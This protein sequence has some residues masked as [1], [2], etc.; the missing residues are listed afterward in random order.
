[1]PK[2]AA[3]QQ[4][5]RKK[6]YKSGDTPTHVRALNGKWYVR[7]VT[8]I[9]KNG[10]KKRKEYWR[11]CEPQT[12]ERS[13]EIYRALAG[14]IEELRN[15]PPKLLFQDV[16]AKFIAVEL[17]PASY[18]P[19]G[20]KIAG[21]RSLATPLMYAKRLRDHFGHRDIR[22]LTFG[23]LQ[24]YKAQLLT[25]P[26]LF[27]TV[28]RPRSIRSV[29]YE[30]GVLR[31]ILNFAVRRRWLD[32]SPF[33]DGKGIINPAAETKR[34]KGWSRIEEAQALALCV[35][36]LVHLKPAIICMVDGGFRPGEL[37]KCKW[38]DVN[39]EAG[40]MLAKSYKGSA[41]QV[42]TIK[43]SKRML[44]V[45]L[46]WKKAQPKRCDR[47]YVIGHKNIK[48]GWSTIR[49]EIGRSDLR[50]HDLRHIF[51]T[52]LADANVPLAYISRTLGHA[53]LVQTSTY[54]NPQPKELEAVVN[55]IDRLNDDII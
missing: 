36:K 29:N 22:N 52:R 48:N 12:V 1:M 10:E 16:T 20:V 14:Q 17:V 51:S 47:H 13:R 8:T 32:R 44:D 34:Y 5:R 41:L 42:R 2:T 7:L 33:M 53:S 38:S 37:L 23:D 25:T 45:L 18:S 4:K 9:L 19:D 30:L 3:V 11:L 50:L 39:F 46:Q 55:A 6:P 43:M 27:K 54:I 40:A 49:A 31:Q 24:D 35:G 15:A 26:V 21:K 28:S